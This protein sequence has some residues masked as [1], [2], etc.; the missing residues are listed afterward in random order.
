MK[1]LQFSFP[2]YFG[3]NSADDGIRRDVF[4]NHTTGGNNRSLP[5]CYSG[6]NYRP[7]PDKNVVFNDD[8]LI[9]RSKV[10]VVDVVLGIINHHLARHID[11]VAYGNW[12]PAI[13][14]HSFANDCIFAHLDISR[15]IKSGAGVDRRTEADFDSRQLIEEAPER[16]TGNK[17]N[18]VKKVNMEFQKNIFKAINN[19]TEKFS[20]R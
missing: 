4:C 11:V 8:G 6:K 17:P 15:V 1:I 14:N 16:M 5:Y 12:R 13:Q 7:W 19:F 10:F 3:R 9:G 18:A 2:Y 20:Q